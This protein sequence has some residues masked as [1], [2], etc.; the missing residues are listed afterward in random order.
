[1][2]KK[3]NTAKAM[4]LSSRWDT[5]RERT[6]QAEDD[7][8]LGEKISEV[9]AG[10]TTTGAAVMTFATG[11]PIA[12]SASTSLFTERNKTERSTKGA[13]GDQKSHQG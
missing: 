11:V 10:E 9:E 4:T 3:V 12:R 2:N 8:L 5:V 13:K 1:M 6:A 7:E